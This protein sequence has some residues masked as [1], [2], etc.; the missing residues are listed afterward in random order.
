[1]S[2]NL[3]ETL[4]YR[5]AQIYRSCNPQE[6]SYLKTILEELRDNGDSPTYRNIWLS[7]YKEIPVDIDT[8]IED[9]LYLGTTN[10]NGA[11]VYPYWRTVLSDIFH[12]G[13]TYEECF[14]TGATRIGKSSTAITATIYM[15]YRLM[16]LRD[17][18]RYFNKKDVSKFSILFFNI[19]KDLARGVGFREFNDTLKASPWFCLRGDT[20][21]LTSLGYKKIA[22]VAGSDIPIY[23]YSTQTHTVELALPQSIQV[24]GYVDELIQIE[25]EDGTVISGTPD[26]RILLTD[27]SYKMLKDVTE[28]DDILTLDDEIFLPIPGYIG[29]YEISTQGRIRV[30]GG[31]K[32]QYS[33]DNIRKYNVHKH[34]YDSIDVSYH[35]VNKVECIPELVMRTFYPDYPSDR[36]HLATDIHDNS[37][38][39]VRPG[40]RYL[41]GD[42]RDVPGTEGL[43]QVNDLGQLY[44]HTHVE[45]TSGRRKI[46]PEHWIKYSIDFDGY[47]YVS[48][49]ILRNLKYHFVHRIVASA[50]LGEYDDLV[51]NHIDGNKQNNC[52][53]NL[54]WCTSKE[55]TEHA[56]ASGLC[57]K[58]RSIIE[59]TS[60]MIFTGVTKAAKHF[61]ISTATVCCSINNN[62]YTQA[63]LRFMYY[64]N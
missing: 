3:V 42:W 17:P 64:E 62:K 26:H 19:T 55:N 36:F 7:D 40:R 16:C 52:I 46:V 61:N 10:R 50:F 49:Q 5:I 14:F 32:N 56:I 21:I 9:D 29:M 60:G 12:A 25:L 45:V 11:A 20:E 23:S 27:G 13:N 30:I 18:Q 28:F 4:P 31:S 63:G 35:G 39:N 38:F 24:T 1:M 47:Y 44:C 41:E 51:V 2:E 6:Q 58:H 37:V 8:F 59:L 43:V 48:E 33:G 54:E 57:F 34:G 22:D 15:L 53:Q